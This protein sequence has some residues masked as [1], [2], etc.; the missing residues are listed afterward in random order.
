MRVFALSDVH[1]DYQENRLWLEGLSN[2]DYQQD[3]LI[4]AGDLS[5]RIELIDNCFK[6]LSAKFYRVLFVAG[7]H[8]LWVLRDKV[9]DSVEKFHLVNKV[10]QDHG[11][12]LDLFEHKG[13]IFAPFL[14]WYDYSFGDPCQ[15][16]KMLWMDFRQCKWPNDMD[17]KQI[18]NYFLQQNS[19]MIHS[20]SNPNDAKVI[21]F[22]HFLPRI[23][24][25]P[26]YIPQMYRYIYPA[27]G[28]AGL[29][30]QIRQIKPDI[31]VYG[32]SHLNRQVDI[33]GVRYINNAFAYPSES[34]IALK[35]LLCIY[36]N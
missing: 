21:S 7:N 26:I 16:L 24:L 31:H 15:K 27:L 4:L 13:V 10:A 20:F 11:I 1:I 28:C 33:D 32:H 5:D 30:K 8:D 29:D 36:E 35:Q 17:D 22:S 19:Q 34:N 23:D 12:G 14:S 2:H 18:T 25:M 6:S 9:D 3:I